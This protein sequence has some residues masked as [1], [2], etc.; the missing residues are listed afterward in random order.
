MGP[1][2]NSETLSQPSPHSGPSEISNKDENNAKEKVEHI[3][4]SR[5]SERETSRYLAAICDL[6]LQS[7]KRDFNT[8]TPKTVIMRVPDQGGIRIEVAITD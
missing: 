1:S 7:L 5:Y 4:V 2:R 3:W 6:L 8:G